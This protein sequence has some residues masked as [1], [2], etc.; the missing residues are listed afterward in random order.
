MEIITSA[1]DKI[2]CSQLKIYYLSFCLAK[3][4]WKRLENSFL[5]RR[6]YF[7][8]PLKAKEDIV[9]TN[10]VFL[11]RKKIFCTCRRTGHR[12]E[13]WQV[14]TLNYIKTNT[15]HNWASCQR[16]CQQCH[17][18]YK[19]IKVSCIIDP[20]HL[21]FFWW[22]GWKIRISYNYNTWYSIEPRNN[23]VPCKKKETRDFGE[24]PYNMKGTWRGQESICRPV[25]N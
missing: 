14:Q 11:S 10:K 1:F 23:T 20:F 9:Y 21:L 25:S 6:C 7:K 2:F 18:M 22:K 8:R 16:D 13:D 19:V 3:W 24:F 5:I 17:G 12:A 15:Y 4:F